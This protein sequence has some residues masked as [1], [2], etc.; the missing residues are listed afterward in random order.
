M[1]I[2]EQ[3]SYLHMKFPQ[4]DRLIIHDRDNRGRAFCETIMPNKKM[5]SLPLTITLAE[6]GCSISVG[7]FENV[8]GFDTMTIEQVCSAIKDIIADKIIFVQGYKDDDETGFGAPCFKRVFALT[9]GKDDMSEDF[10][11]FIKQISKP[12]GKFSR[13]FTNLKGRFVIYNFSGT[14]N[15]E[16]IR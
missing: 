1:T 13:I 4:F 14:V 10:E 6:R 7:P 3:I 8:T 2:E 15:K 9:G 12:L 5:P 11:D 16:I